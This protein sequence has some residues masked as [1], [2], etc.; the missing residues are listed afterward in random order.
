MYKFIRPNYD[1]GSIVNLM[2]SISQS[3][4]KKHQYKEL[5]E[6]ESKELKKFKNIV[7]IIIDGLGYDYLCNMKDSFLYSNLRSKITSTFLSTTT[8]ANTCFLTGYP[9]QQHGLTG[10]NINLKEVGAITKIL[11]FI[12]IFDGEPLSKSG[13]K[14]EHIMDIKPFHKGFT[15]NCFKII[16]KKISDGEFTR[17]TSKASKIIP[18]KNYKYVFRKIKKIVKKKSDKRK[19]IH[20]YLWELDSLLHKEGNKGKNAGFLFSEL[21]KRIKK[22][23]KQIQDTKTCIIVTADHGFIDI[24]IKNQLFIENIPGLK[25]CL[26]MPLAGEPRVRDCFVRPSKTKDFEKIVRTKMSKYCWCFK[27]EQLIKDNF[28]GIGKPN[29]R[30]FDRVGDYVLIMKENYSLKDKLANYDPNKVIHLGKHGGVSE[31]EMIVPLV[32]IKA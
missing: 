32:F 8:C 16:D 18:S 31:N 26:S 29:K 13:F 10:W 19:F 30:L 17:Y 7:L 15:G 3:F 9:A 20:A 12:P 21:D 11:P 6:L 1:N 2:S 24:P 27:G 5:P 28:Y 22:L 25:D 23:A 14:M 4:G